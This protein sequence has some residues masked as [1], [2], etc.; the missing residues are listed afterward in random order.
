MTT[1]SPR[2]KLPVHFPLGVAAGTLVFYLLF[3]RPGVTLEGL[4]L[5]AQFAGWN[6]QPLTGQPLLWLLTL[7][8]HL[9]PAA[10]MTG[11]LSCFSALTA[12]VL[13]GWLARSVT[14]LPW[15]RAWEPLPG[16]NLP[17][18][19]AVAVC[20]LELNF[21]QQ[22]TAAS[23]E[24]LNL[25]PLVAALWLLLE[26]RA[27]HGSR[28]LT[29]AVFV[30]GFGLAGNGLMLLT[31]PL[32]VVGVIRLQ[33][34]EHFLLKSWR[35]LAGW[36]GA[37]IFAY[38][39]LTIFNDLAVHSPG[40]LRLDLLAGP[41]QVKALALLF[42][43]QIWRADV[44]L[45]LVVA[46]YFLGPPLGFLVRL[47]SAGA[48]RQSGV[49]RF[50]TLV[51]QSLRAVL[52]LA[53]LWLAFDPLAGPR[54]VLQQQCHQVFPL[55]A[56]DYLNALGAGFLAGNLLLLLQG[57]SRRQRQA[58]GLPW[59]AWSIPL[60]TGILVLL[61]MGLLARN[62]PAIWR[63]HHHPLQDFGELVAD[64]LPAG[65][66]ILLGDSPEKLAVFQAALAH[67]PIRSEWLTVDLRRLAEPAYRTALERRQS[68][69]WL[70][71]ETRHELAPPE[72]LRLLAQIIRA[73][74][75]FCL[76]PG[77]G[78]LFDP[79][80]QIPLGAVYE[81]KLRVPA[82]PVAPPL[83]ASVLAAGEQL[84]TAAWPDRLAAL[85]IPTNR[86]VTRWSKA[87][88]KLSLAPVALLQ[89]QWLA[90][91]Y[92]QA[93]DGWAVALQQQGHWTEARVR[94][95]QALLLVTN[96]FSAG[97]GLDCN[98]AHQAGRPMPVVEQVGSLRQMNGVWDRYGP[99]DDPSFCYLLGY[100]DQ[101]N[102]WFLQAVDQFERAHA[103][104]P[105][106]QAPSL[107]LANLYTLIHVPD[108][109]RALLDQVRAEVKN[110][111]AN[112]ALDTEIAMLEVNYWVAQTNT[113]AA[114]TALR[115][116]LA[117]HP[118]DGQ[119]ASQARNAFFTF[120]DFT[121]A[122]P[123]IRAELAVSPDD[124]AALSMQAAILVQSG[125]AVAALPVLDHVLTL[126]NL[127]AARLSRAIARYQC[128]DL[129]AAEADY[130]VLE[131][132]GEALS[133]V[134]FG[135]AAIAEQ[136]HD[137]SRTAWYLRACLTNLPSGAPLWQQVSNQL[138][139]IETAPQ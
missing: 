44:W 121:N 87:T 13:L 17:V 5:T 89:D 64:S 133:S 11:G 12:A 1:H 107:A 92:S 134:Y 15:D 86:P 83:D 109:A 14:L 82:A 136:R 58:G 34:L 45:T 49:E 29:T 36:G 80:Y 122:L 53:L 127:P 71:D 106:V 16:A 48:G 130:L 93:L 20:G 78:Y 67:R 94:F 108:R 70:T 3:V 116:L 77:H 21:W 75:L 10:W 131:K 40:S 54:Q 91:W 39:L 84:W 51:Y 35:R 119:I 24:I 98:G 7:P 61:T 112:T 31:L 101:Q 52:L 100:L 96:N 111:P 47:R 41:L 30:W 132:T 6:E 68:A 25:L 125:Q 120:G 114:R 126:T 76:Q 74:R 27:E 99:L 128:R 72:V 26:Y 138:H 37:G 59:R 73:H 4:P 50:E 8:L 46:V 22:A 66:G 65:P 113:V 9:L 33:G 43:H 85:V 19:L 38:L 60:A 137:R 57:A 55:L 90:G 117:Q 104:A 102:G 118:G 95:G 88:R 69:G 63:A 124:I 32:F 129:A 110:L 42:Y 135:L 23:S 81:M 2:P 18:A 105:Q 115:V 28:R 139:S 62:G 56:Y 79:F 103:L 123:I 97:V